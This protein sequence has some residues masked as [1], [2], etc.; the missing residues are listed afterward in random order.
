MAGAAYTVAELAAKVGGAVEGDGAARVERVAPLEEAGPGAV[1]F[2]S[3]KKYRGAFEASRA[4]AVIVEPG[5]EVPA[6]RTV[7]R[8]A[9]PYLAFA[10]VS[11]L[12]NPPRPAAA[13]ISPQAFVHPTAAVDATAEVMPFAYVGP[14]AAVGARTTLHPGAHV[15]EGARVGADCV[16]YPNVSVRDACVVGDR[17]ILQPGCVIGSDGFGFAFDPQGEGKGPRHYK[18]PQIGNVVVEDDVEIGACTT[19]DRAA[20]GSTVVGRGAKIDNLVQIAH[21]VRVGPLSIIVS[22]VGVS[23]STKLGMGV[24]LGGQAG[25]TGH[26]TIGDG[27]KIAAQSGVMEDVEP[28]AVLLGSPARPRGDAMRIHVSMARLPE[29]V[30]K[31]RDLEKQLAKLEKTT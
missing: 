1:S 31:V 27:A 10:K 29:L 21:N 24:V 9:N 11:T 4:A 12:F 28:G 30:R 20:L 26:L 22:Q 14:G 19:V 6:G 18:V 25:I 7:I 8:A 2:F 16:L 13:G 15:G 23:G 5:E 3:N 17:V